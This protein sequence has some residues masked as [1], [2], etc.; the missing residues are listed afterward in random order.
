MGL[1]RA[2]LKECR[3]L[4]SLSCAVSFTH[5]LKTVS[6]LNTLKVIDLV[7]FNAG[8]GHQAAAIALQSVIREQNR[9]WRVR[10]VNLFEVLD[11]QN[12]FRKVTGLNPEDVYNKRLARGWTLGLAQ[13]LKL[14]QALIRISHKTMTR[15]LQQHWRETTPDMVVSLV[16]NFNRSMYDAVAATLPG[17]PYVTILTDFADYPPHFWMEP[18]QEQHLICGTAKAA[19]QALSGG[20]S[21]SVV[22]ETSGMIIRPDFYR[23]LDI[24]RIAER[25]KIGLDA[26]RPTAIVLFG[27]HGSSMMHRIADRLYDTQLIL[28]CGHNAKLAARLRA[29]TASAPRH[30]VGFTPDVRYFMSLSDF[31]I[32]KPGPASISEAIHQGLPVILVRNAYTMPQERYNTDWVQEN[33][34]GIVLKSFKSVRHAA[35]RVSAG[36]ADF[37]ENLDRV[38][39]RAVFE[40]PVIFERIFSA[41]PPSRKA[42][43]YVPATRPIAESYSHR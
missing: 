36:L 19:L 28:M 22:H 42:H 39:N 15:R 8:G 16:P 24:D 7:Y 2:R 33:G 25:R 12:L 6:R 23:R 18:D 10:L 14:L 30:V 29:M 37:R 35:A 13:E 21:R 40:I 9:P 11:P 27:G 20:L 34:A 5:T 41:N 1:L 4:K 17:V 3:N 43:D 26:D 38:R 32:G 31:F